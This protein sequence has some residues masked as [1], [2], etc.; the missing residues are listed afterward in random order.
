ML[1]Q[2]GFKVDF[3]MVWGYRGVNEVGSASGGLMVG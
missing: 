3:A 2:S 1:D